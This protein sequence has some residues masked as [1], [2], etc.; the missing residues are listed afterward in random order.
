M[1]ALLAALALVVPVGG[2]G[3]IRASNVSHNKPS[4]FVLRGRVTVPLPG[5]D[6]RQAG[7]ACAAPVSL[8]DIAGGA[9][10]KVTDPDG[11]EIALGTLGAGIVARSSRGASCD[12]PFEIRAVPGGVD[13]YAIAVAGRAPQTFPAK[14]LREDQAAVITIAPSPSG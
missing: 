5:T 13:S 11:H 14:A 1:A 9:A 12:F 3:F 10:V 4:G 6:Q 2:C 8:P 7:A